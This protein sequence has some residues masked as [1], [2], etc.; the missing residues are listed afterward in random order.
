MTKAELRAAIADRV[1]NLSP[2]YCR[3]ADAAI[4]AHVLRSPLYESAR[5]IFCYVGTSRE[6]DTM[7]LLHAALRDGKALALP[8]CQSLGVMEAR[9][10]NDL[11]DLVTGRYNILAP[12]LQCPL[13]EPEDLDLAIVPCCTANSRGQR[14][15]Y[16]GGFYDRYLTRVKC[17]TVVLCRRHIVCEDI[18][19]EDYDQIMDYLVTE[20]GI[21]DC[22]QIRF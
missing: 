17:P 14:L 15:G 1:K 16:G 4:C 5:T 3:E 21:A 20:R 8:Y 9:R 2:V 10:I 19:V 7:P 22:R 11:S 18:P 12:K 6:I 13:V